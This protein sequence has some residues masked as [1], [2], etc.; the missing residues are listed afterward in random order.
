MRLD[1]P[2]GIY[3]VLAPCLWTIAFAANSLWQIFVY[4]PVFILGAVIVRGIGCI[5]NDMV[6]QKI[7]KNVERTKSRPLANGDLDNS[8]ARKFLIILLAMAFILLLAIPNIAKIVAALSLIPIACYPYMKYVTYFPQV[9]LGLVFN[10]GVIIAWLTVSE[11]FSFIPIIIYLAAAF[12]TI[13]YDT[14]YAHQDRDDD[15][16]NGL[17]SLAIKLDKKTSLVVWQLYL[18]SVGLLCLVGLNLHMNFI[19]FGGIALAAYHMYWQTATL[20]I[21]D[22]KNCNERFFSNSE[23]GAIIFIAVLL[24]RLRIF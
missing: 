7:D 8:A 13:G 11:S 4:I 18:S 20:D 16:K 17:K 10:L 19:F 3:L 22:P 14:I 12:W 9:V 1:K 24:G 2:I 5:I 6:D 21:N 15:I 23:V